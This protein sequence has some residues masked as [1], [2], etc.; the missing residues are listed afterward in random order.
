MRKEFLTLFTAYHYNIPMNKKIKRYFVSILI[1]LSLANIFAISKA[2]KYDNLLREG[3]VKQLSEALAKDND[4]Y[5]MTFGKERNNILMQVLKYDRPYEVVRLI[6]Q[7][8]IR[9][10]ARNRNKMDAVMIA[11]ANSS[12]RSVIRYIIKRSTKPEEIKER[13]TSTRIGG[14]SPVEYA[15]ENPNPIALKT[16]NE[17]IGLEPDLG[18][19]SDEEAEEAQKENAEEETDNNSENAETTENTE[20]AIPAEEAVQEDLPPSETI[21][22][23]KI[24]LFDYAPQ[25]EELTPEEVEDEELYAKIDNPDQKDKMDRTL[26]MLA[27]KDGN[28]WEVKSLLNSKAKVNLKDKDGWTALMYAA[29]YQNNIDLIK[30]LVESGADTKAENKYG[31]TALQIAAAY[32]NNPAIIK[33]LIECNPDSSAEIFKSFILSITAGG[34]NQVTQIGKLKIFLEHGVPVNRFYEGKTPLM[35]AC[36]FGTTTDL[37]KILLENGAITKVRTGNGKTAF[38]FAQLNTHLEHNDVYWSLNER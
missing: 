36:E 12:S 15:A 22:Y 3:D 25:D 35:Y 7:T 9:L 24:Y 28:D 19:I 4:F 17:L 16:V 38:D 26:L 37:I 13:L 34:G 21:N 8:G 10:N 1:F 31:S 18:D 27:A 32:S 29:R 20:E 2:K 5:R 23:N 6:S 14:K 33:Y 11:C 30:K